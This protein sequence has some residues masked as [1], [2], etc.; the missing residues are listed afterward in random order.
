MERER[1]VLHVCTIHFATEACL[2][3]PLVSRASTQQHSLSTCAR[4]MAPPLKPSTRAQGRVGFVDAPRELVGA[5]LK[6]MGLHY[7]TSVQDLKAAGVSEED[8]RAAVAR[9]RRQAR[10]FYFSAACSTPLQPLARARACWCCCSAAAGKSPAF[11]KPTDSPFPLIHPMPG[12]GAAVQQP[13]SRAR[14]HRR[15]LLGGRRLVI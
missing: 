9:L 5:A 10:L 7:N 4:M 3:Q 11:E 12:A 14:A 6:S 8:V 15:R 2:A 1:H 13:R